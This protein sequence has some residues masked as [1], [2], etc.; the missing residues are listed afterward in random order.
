MKNQIRFECR[1]CG[2]TNIYNLPLKYI[3]DRDKRKENVNTSKN[4]GR[5]LKKLLLIQEDVLENQD[6]LDEL[7]DIYENDK[8]LSGGYVRRPRNVTWLSRFWDDGH[9]VYFKAKYYTF[10][11][12][13]KVEHFDMLKYAYTEEFVE[14]SLDVDISYVKSEYYIPCHCCI[15]RFYSN[16]EERQ[17]ELETRYSDYYDYEMALTE[18]DDKIG[19]KGYEVY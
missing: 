10:R 18:L 13:L 15:F 2:V 9:K 17:K 6:K 4:A 14:E 11:E 1:G 8:S 3:L 12:F 16:N 7:H 5:G 19:H